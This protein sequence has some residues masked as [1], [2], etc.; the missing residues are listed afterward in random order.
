MMGETPANDPRLMWQSQRRDHPVM[1]VEEVRVMAQKVHAKVRRNV[2]IAFVLGLLLL[3][4][5]TL[6]IAGGLATSMQVI[7]GAM[8]VVT[9][10]GGYKAWYRIWPLHTLSA[11]AALKG[12]L[13]F[14]RKE[15]EAQ[16]RSIA[17]TWRFLVPAVVFT[18]LIWNAIFTTSALVPRILLPS[19]LVLTFFA[20][21]RE[22]RRFKHK[23]VRLDE[24]ERENLQ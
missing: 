10:V 24:F 23:L 5:G 19:V 14:Y 22:V 2:I 13:D 17:L 15:L 1:S 16:Y 21:H 9:V 11:D 4:L 12:C 20:R 6:A 18:F 7:I 3:V 8:M